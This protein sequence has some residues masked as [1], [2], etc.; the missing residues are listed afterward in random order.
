MNLEKFGQSFEVFQC[1]LFQLWHNWLPFVQLSWQEN[2][3]K[4]MIIANSGYKIVSL[5]TWQ[6]SCRPILK[7]PWIVCGV[8]MIC[9]LSWSTLIGLLASKK[10]N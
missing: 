6:E 10:R 3:Y 2:E 7:S 5:T 4:G 8:W 9:F 1:A